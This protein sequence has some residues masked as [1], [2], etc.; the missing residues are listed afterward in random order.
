[1]SAPLPASIA[2]RIK[3]LHAAL[4]RWLWLVGLSRVCVVAVVL[5]L[6]DFAVDRYFRMDFAQRTVSLILSLAALAYVA[7]RELGRVLRRQIS[8][9]ELTWDLELRHPELGQSVISAVGFSAGAAPGTSSAMVQAT[10]AEG[11]RRIGSIQVEDVLDATRRNRTLAVASAGVLLL[12][13][14]AVVMPGDAWLWFR[15]NVL[16]GSVQWPQRT[17][18]EISHLR[19]GEL[20]LPRGDDLE[21]WVQAQ[22]VVPGS[23]GIEFKSKTGAG[24]EQ[25]VRVGQS[26]FRWSYRNVLDPMRLRVYGGDAVSEWIPVKLAERP[27]LRTIRLSVQPPAYTGLPKAVLPPGEGSYFV[28]RG[29]VLEIAGTASTNIANL[30]FSRGKDPLAAKI[31]LTGEAFQIEVPPALLQT[32]VYQIVLTDNSGLAAKAPA[33]FTLK[34]ADD[35]KPAVRVRLEGVGDLITQRASIPINLKVT[36]DFG[37]T[38]V[39]LAHQQPAPL[40]EGKAPETQPTVQRMPLTGYKK[41]ADGKELSHQFRFEITPL[42]LPLDMQLVFHVEAADNDTLNG[43]KLGQSQVFSLKVVTDEVLRN[44]LLRREQEQRQEFERSIDQQKGLLAESGDI[45]RLAAT[46]ADWAQSEHRRLKEAEKR[47]RL[48]GQRCE[49]IATQFAQILAEV[50]NNRLEDVG[51]A[52]HKRL[53]EG[54][55]LPLRAL[56]SS[57]LPQAA[58]CLDQ[59]ATAS[60]PTATRREALQK[61]HAL[62]ERIL[63]RM[64]EVLK[65][66][67]KWEGY[68]E[69]VLMVRELL[70]DQQDINEQTEKKQKEL[71]EKIFGK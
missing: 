52:I 2:A 18:L 44:E 1:M 43:P 64:R 38:A 31:A 12:L 62:Q 53:Q 51:G 28:L 33:R 59:A 17:Q 25:M 26:G 10:I 16:L 23:V 67:V 69:A 55:I 65:N 68:Q 5:V 6:V 46:Q 45:K 30:G 41:S 70:K 61:A 63:A 34:I 24:S 15:R 27:T 19:N 35:A 14:A 22:G 21:L 11:A 60:L 42:K 47:Q 58:D 13:A 3:A 8:V 49:A 40:V 4:R 39:A 54:I 29:S 56:A 36:D 50:E 48:L 37:I 7:Y 57:H 9:A 32:G 20:W 71:I 66:M